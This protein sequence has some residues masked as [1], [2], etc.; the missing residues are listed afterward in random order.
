[1]AASWK[2]VVFF[3]YVVVICIVCIAGE[4]SEMMG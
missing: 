4:C 2:G 1:M 3:K